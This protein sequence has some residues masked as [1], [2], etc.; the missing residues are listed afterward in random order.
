MSISRYKEV[1]N[2]DTTTSVEESET[3][4][5]TDIP[6]RISFTST[7]N[8]E[9]TKE[10]SNPVYLQ[11]KVFCSPEIDVQK[12]D[13]IV[14]QRIDNSGNVIATYKGTA[15]LPLQYVTHKEILLVQ[16]GDA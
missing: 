2:D 15:N 12:G 1:L 13:K 5:Y 9:T 4:V 11:I 16:V 7:D 3:P 8:P 6:C 10:D 14:A